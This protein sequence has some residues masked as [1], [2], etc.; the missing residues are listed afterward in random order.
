MSQ[1]YF[2]LKGRELEPPQLF[3]DE[4]LKSLLHRKEYVYILD[5]AC[6]Q[7]EPDDP[8]YQKITSKVYQEINE[9]NDFEVLRSTRHF[10]PIAFFLAWF[11]MID[12][13][14]MELISTSNIKDANELLELYN[15]LNEKEQIGTGIK[16]KDDNDTSLI[17]R[18]ISQNSS[19]KGQLELVMQSYK[20]VLK[21][22]TDIDTN[23]K[24]AHG[25]T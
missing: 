5:R 12:N 15:R 21:Q 19:K 9:N 3:N 10:G 24:K 1:I 13:L 2:P 8:E 16:L 22:K 6:V 14:L 11:K 18:Y 25:L 4:N 17:E 7:F 20:E 23:I